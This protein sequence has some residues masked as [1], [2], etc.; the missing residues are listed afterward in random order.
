VCRSQAR[1]GS[2]AAARSRVV[3]HARHMWQPG[4]NLATL[5]GARHARCGKCCAGRRSRQ[6]D[7]DG[8]LVPR[9]DAEGDPTICPAERRNAGHRARASAPTEEA[10]E[11]E[12]TRA[13]DDEPAEEG[14]PKQVDVRPG[15][16]RVQEQRLH[17]HRGGCQA[18]EQPQQQQSRTE[19]LDRDTESGCCEVVQQPRPSCVCAAGRAGAGHHRHDCERQEGLRKPQP[20]QD[21]EPGAECLCCECRHRGDGPHRE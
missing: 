19:S 7:S 21:I 9:A 2:R 8:D 1:V 16:S 15:A 6:P 17:E 3:V 12:G 11:G 4:R 14:S 18:R 5:H 10:V 20:D 13:H